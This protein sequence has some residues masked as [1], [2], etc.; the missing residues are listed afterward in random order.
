[1]IVTLMPKSATS[2]ASAWLSPSS[3]P[4]GGVV[5]TD[6]RH[7]ADPTDAG[8]LQDVPG[9]LGAQERQRRLGHPQHA[10]E[11]GLELGAGILLGDLLD[12][13]ELSV[14]GIVDDDVEP[15]EVLVRAANGGEVSPAVGDVKPQRQDAVAEALDQ[16]IQGGRVAGGGG[17]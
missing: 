11:V 2:W 6:V 4:L 8:H 15:A 16:V 3:A 13:A 7:G 9:A 12:H 1:M 17:H 10:E 14:T 5:D